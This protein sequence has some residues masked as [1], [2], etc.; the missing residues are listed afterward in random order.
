MSILAS[1][2]NAPADDPFAVDVTD[3]RASARRFWRLTLRFATADGASSV[4]FDPAL[5]D[6]CLTLTVDGVEFG[7]V[8]PPLELRPW[9]LEMGRELLAGGKWRARL[10]WFIPWF[11][12][13]S[14]TGRIDVEYH[15][16]LIGWI[17]E[18]RSA[19]NDSPLVLHRQYATKGQ[20]DRS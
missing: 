5:G 9:L 6:D 7:L 13:S 12:R 17:G 2:D 15:G 18:F 10:V 1:G 8:P 20:D 11:F 4:R 3:D 16:E 19:A 14:H